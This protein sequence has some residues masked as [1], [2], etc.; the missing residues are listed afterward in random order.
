MRSLQFSVVRTTSTLQTLI[1]LRVLNFLQ[2]IGDAN[3]SSIRH[4][5]IWPIFLED[6]DGKDFLGCDYEKGE[7]SSRAPGLK[8]LKIYFGDVQ[9]R[10]C[11]CAAVF[12]AEVTSEIVPKL[13]KSGSGTRRRRP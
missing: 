9:W 10:K 8:T 4:M 11:E 7:L 1:I 6:K 3:A 5:S 12:F 13:V 2:R